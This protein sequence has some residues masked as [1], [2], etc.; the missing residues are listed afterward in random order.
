ME[1]RNPVLNREFSK[2]NLAGFHQPPPSS[3]TLQDMYDGPGRIAASD[4]V[5][6]LDD[7]VVKTWILFTILVAA[8]VGG[9]YAFQ[10]HPVLVLVPMFVALGLGIAVSVKRDASPALIMAYA[11]FE[12][13]F[14]GAISFY[15]QSYATLR[16]G[17]PSN[18]VLQAVIGTFVAFGVM[19]LLY[20]TGRLRATPRFQKMMMIALVS[21]VGIALV[22]FVSSMFNVGGGWGFYG[23]GGMGLLLC[24]AGVAL[25]AFTLVLDFD[26]I[27]KGIAAGVPERES[28]RASFGLMVSLVW[29]YLELVRL[30][31]ILQGRN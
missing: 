14:V 8:A 28:W 31:A 15:Y 6:T 22:S 24:A 11:A 19:L 1:S 10:Q 30:L 7:V 25:A 17:Q 4:R 9:W 21:Y 5:M 29:L 16:S 2:A 26:M 12:G 13:V 20:K 27:E 3:Q 23:V 18:I